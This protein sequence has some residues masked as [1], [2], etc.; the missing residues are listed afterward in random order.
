MVFSLKIKG[1]QKQSLISRHTN[2]FPLTKGTFNNDINNDNYAGKENGYN[3]TVWLPDATG[4][5][6][7]K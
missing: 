7:C 1:M 4:Y 5:E 6:K 2:N 3:L